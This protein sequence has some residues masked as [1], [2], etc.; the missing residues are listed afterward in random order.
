MAYKSFAGALCAGASVV[1]IASGAYAQQAPGAGEAKAV[2]EVVVTGSRLVAAGF[3]A[4]TPV[5]VV[6][7]AVI[8]QR[9]PANISDVILEQPAFRIANT[10]TSRQGSGNNSGNALP[11]G[12]QQ[13]LDLRGLGAA[14]TL[15]LIN[16]HRSVGTNWDST[17]DSNIV[18]VGLVERIDTVTG[19]A[20]AAYG[21][22][23]VAGVVNIILANKLE[24]I[25]ATT[26]L[27]VTEYGSAKQYTANI[28]GGHAFMD[29]R[30]HVIGGIDYNKSEAITDTYGKQFV[31]DELGNF[32]PTA[33]DRTA[34]G[35]PQTVIAKGVEPASSAPGG[36][37][38]VGTNAFTFDSNGNPVAI[39]RGTLSSNG[40]LMTG[41]TSN[42]GRNLNGLAPLRLPT[43]R[44]D[45][46]GRAQYDISDN[47]DAYIEVTDAHSWIDPY[48]VSEFNQG[49]GW[50]VTLPAITVART[51]PFVTPA[52]LALIG[53]AQTFTI[54]RN[55][56]EL[57]FS[58]ISGN[59][60][61]LKNHTYRVVTGLEGSFGD[62]WKWNT[63]Y[64]HGETDLRMDRN[65]FS[66][67]AL[68]KAVNGCNT[69]VGFSA[70]AITL[71][72]RYET[73]SGK[74]CSP[75]NPF[76]VGRASQAAI[77][78]IQNATYQTNQ[79]TLNVVE[80]NISGSPFTLPAGDVAVAAGAEW[81]KETLN[82]G[83]D[84]VSRV[85]V[86]VEGGVLT[87]NVVESHGEESVKEAYAEVGV[88]ILKDVALAKSL[89]FDS[90]VRVTDYELSGTVTTWKAGLVWQPLDVLRFRYTKSHDIRAPNLRALFFT[91]GPN[92][93][94]VST[95]LIPVGTVGLNG[96]VYNP[97]GNT[98][99][100][101]SVASNANAA[102]SVQVPGGSGNPALRPE[103]A[104]TTTAGVVFSWKGFDASIDYYKIEMTDQIAGPGAQVAI[105]QCVAGDRTYCNFI[106]FDQTTPGGIARLEPLTLNLN[107][108]E[109]NGVDYEVGYR[110]RLGPG[111]F[112][113]RALVNYQPHNYSINKF[114]GQKTETANTI[115]GQPKL[116]Y[117]LSATYIVDRFNFN[118]QVRGF[119]ERIGN[120]I[121][122]NADGTV[123]ATSVLGPEDAGYTAA[124][125]NTIS[126]NRYP[127]Q[128]FVNPSV[129]YKVNDKITAFVNID[130]VFDKSPPPLTTSAIYDLIGR[131][132]RFGLRMNF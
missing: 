88:P 90:A 103:I 84:P 106:T 69:S 12:V 119:A 74:T 99:P 83:V 95:L 81:R 82:A 101:G 68:Q 1:A 70:V 32:S 19:G 86:A 15:T 113:V 127:G 123:A 73:L 6:G 78:Y 112:S 71:V 109:L 121:I 125:A 118:V 21:S 85:G 30:L 43:S 75:F 110:G 64:Q 13:T 61:K 44:L 126:K 67:Y 8:D 117:N 63:S 111:A 39:S 122:Y 62:K 46:M 66:A 129:S 87:N 114:T 55:N 40:Q 96:S 94:N 17:V 33:A 100:K 89:D 25:R 132:Y 53:A 77:D 2:E 116:A 4:P 34:L 10:E 11:Q 57:S 79:L 128:Y 31:R 131:R 72:N 47:L 76:G 51:N 105:D 93:T 9:A 28:A 7:K 115:A 26:Q 91:G 52:T 98:A 60:A 35:L 107:K 29:G 42:Y 37:L 18:P 22:D 65:D 80:A 23:A 59:A 48:K 104:D 54:G 27:G 5:T 24:G 49:A 108:A 92:A 41:S 20:S 45:F 97:I 36:L 58:G 16:G 14:R 130:N 56:T 3:E 38:V 120:N 102:L 124:R 50:G